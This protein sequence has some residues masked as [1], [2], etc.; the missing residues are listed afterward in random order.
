MMY[1]PVHLK[2]FIKLD[3]TSGP[4]GEHLVK[5]GSKHFPRFSSCGIYHSLIHFENFFQSIPYAYMILCLCGYYFILHYL[6]MISFKVK[7]HHLDLTGQC[8][9]GC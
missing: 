9:F 1:F 4:L 6:P 7:T 5:E 3:F 8:L 2:K